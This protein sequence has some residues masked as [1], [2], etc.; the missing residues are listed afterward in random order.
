MRVFDA[1][2]SAWPLYASVG[3]IVWAHYVY[4]DV[5]GRVMLAVVVAF[6]VGVGVGRSRS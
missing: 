4:G 6:F 2:V 3:L 1:L 5:A